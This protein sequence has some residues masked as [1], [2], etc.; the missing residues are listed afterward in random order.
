MLAYLRIDT[1]GTLFH[2]L[3]QRVQNH[4]GNLQ[5][6]PSSCRPCGWSD[7]QQGAHTRRGGHFHCPTGAPGEG[8]PD[9]V[10]VLPGA[11]PENLS[12]ESTACRHEGSQGGAPAVYRKALLLLNCAPYRK[13]PPCPQPQEP[14]FR[15]NWQQC[16]E[17]KEKPVKRGNVTSDLS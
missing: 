3:F 1:Q 11:V 13:A 7:A 4:L 17:S 15:F 5:Y 6:A 12:Q 2:K 9:D 14:G 10:Q 16:Q 8:R